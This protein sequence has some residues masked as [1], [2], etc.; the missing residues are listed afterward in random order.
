M[1]IV[2]G[3]TIGVVGGTGPAGRGLASRLADAGRDVLLGSRDTDRA[4]S[5]VASLDAMWPGRLTEL[6]ACSNHEAVEADL[7]VLGTNWEGAVPTASEHAAALAHK[8]VISMANA[9]SKEG[10][11]FRAVMPPEGSMAEAIQRAAPEAFVVG[12]FQLL[13]AAALGDLTR[14]LDSDVLVTADAWEHRQEVIA[15]IDSVAGL[16]GLHA[17]PLQNV[18][19]I[20]TLTA[21]LLTVNRHH[22]G[23]AV[24]RLDGINHA[25]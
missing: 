13:P 14:A 7:V 24:L 15:V 6:R 3:Q 11:E 5:A 17:G 2:V 1:G 4:Q 25:L 10:H 12:A 18:R 22:G 9:L 19:G 16:R 20:E 23:E 8:V 21:A